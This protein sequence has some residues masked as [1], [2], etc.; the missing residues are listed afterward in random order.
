MSGLRLK[1]D[2]LQFAHGTVRPLRE[3]LLVKP[4]PPHLS[5][6]IHADWNGEAVRGEVIAAGP[7][8]YP[9]LHERGERD[10]KSYRRVKQL[11]AFRPCDVKVGDVVQLGGMEL[12]GYLWPHVQVGGVDC[13]LISEQ[14]VC[15]I[16]VAPSM[17]CEY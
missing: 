6:T 13:I 1:N 4:L 11:A 8:T 17:G 9:N 16:E 14:D 7:G 15:G 12:G 3:K 10:G 5:Q 2:A